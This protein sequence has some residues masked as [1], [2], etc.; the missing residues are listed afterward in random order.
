MPNVTDVYVKSLPDIYRDILKVF[1]DFVPDRRAGYALAFQSLYAY[2]R[3]KWTLAQ[4]ISACERMEKAGAVEI[5][6]KIFVQPTEFGE[7]IIAALIGKHA[8]VADS[9]P[10]FPLPSG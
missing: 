1:P 7:D 10:E 2:L 3:E 6:N 5:K 9:V 4:I 8:P